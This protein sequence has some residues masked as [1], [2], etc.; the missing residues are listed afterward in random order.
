MGTYSTSQRTRQALIDA[1]GE[2]ITERGVGRVSTRAI[3]ERAGENL[4]TIHYHFGGKEE[5][6]KEVL[7]FACQAHAGPPL[8]E[9]IQGF[10][11]RL[12]DVQGQVEVVRTVVQHV[13]QRIFAPDRPP[14]CSRVLYQVVQHAGP[15]RDFLRKETIDPYFRAMTGLISR[16][17]PDWTTKEIY[18]WVHMVIGPIVFHADHRETVLDRFD[19]D[20][21][22]ADYLAML[23][24]RLAT[25][26]IRA[27]GLPPEAIQRDDTQDVRPTS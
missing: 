6:F 2:L 3:A 23:E 4:G 14:W 1:A 17:R 19:L 15:L 18:L 20:S 12:D 10:E 9:V 21:F 22:P 8:P 13:M 24:H 25:D 16:I 27:L 11:D 26:A 7:R 5:L